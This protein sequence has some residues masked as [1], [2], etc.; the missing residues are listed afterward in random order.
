[1]NTASGCCM[2]KREHH[3][4]LAKILAA[5]NGEFLEKAECYFGGGSALSM[6]MGEYRESIDLDF[7]CSSAEGYRL[8]RNAASGDMRLLIDGT[9]EQVGPLRMTQDKISGFFSID[10]QAVKIEFI[11]E[12][13]SPVHGQMDI[14]L[15]VPVASLE[16]LFCQKLMA[17]ADRALDRASAS[18]DI[19]D[20]AMMVRL[21]GE[22]PEASWVRAHAAYGDYLVRGFHSA[23][24][25]IRSS[26]YLKDCLVKMGMDPSLV[27]DIQQ[28][29]DAS[30]ILIPVEEG[31]RQ[32]FDRRRHLLGEQAD[33]ACR[34]LMLSLSSALPSLEGSG[35]VDWI[36]VEFCTLAEMVLSRGGDQEEIAERISA[37]SPAAAS[38]QRR[39]RILEGL[40]S[41]DLMA[42]GYI[43]GQ[44][45][46][47]SLASELPGNSPRP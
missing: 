38:A 14:D 21:H 11:R 46:A 45:A 36:S 3:R 15:G 5:L 27:G 6:K 47:E 30:S 35:S 32:E 25:V 40:S 2:F 4:R 20:L 26:G 31:V 29:A 24:N 37:I 34:S 33:D 12:G 39:S 10:G 23:V 42:E 13:N 19:I 7:L 28:A 44:L 18:R 16:D 22:I 43:W 1:M 41:M 8:L 17:N 9:V